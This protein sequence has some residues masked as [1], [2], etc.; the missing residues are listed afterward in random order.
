MLG[1]KY[2]YHS[3]FTDAETEAQKGEV[4]C[5]K[6]SK[7]PTVLL[8]VWNCSLKLPPEVAWPILWNHISLEVSACWS[9]YVLISP[10]L[11]CTNI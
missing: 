6:P 2:D 11:T 3:H 9:V 1:D 8:V 10:D 4:I 5:P 7:F